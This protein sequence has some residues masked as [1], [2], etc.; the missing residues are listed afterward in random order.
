MITLKSDVDP[1]A[2]LIATEKTVDRFERFKCMPV[3]TKDGKLS[4]E[5]NNA[6]ICVTLDDGKPKKLGSDETNGYLFRIYYE[7]KRI[8]LQCIHALADGRGVVFF[9]SCLIKN[10]YRELSIEVDPDNQLN[11][12]GFFKEYA[13]AEGLFASCQKDMAAQN[14][15]AEDILAAAKEHKA[16]I[17][18]E[19]GKIHFGEMEYYKTPLVGVD[20]LIYDAAKCKEVVSGFGTTVAIFLNMLINK[21]I[22]EEYE[23]EGDYIQSLLPV[24]MRSKFGVTTCDNFCSEM[25]L[26]FYKDWVKDSDEEMIERISADYHEA[27]S[28]ELLISDV[29]EMEKTCEAMQSMIPLTFPDMESLIEKARGK[30]GG[31]T[32]QSNM[33]L[34]RLPGHMGEYVE[35]IDFLPSVVAPDNEFVTSTYGSK[36]RILH[37]S[38]YRDD[39]V[40]KKVYEYMTEYG[41]PAELIPC[42]SVENDHINVSLFKKEA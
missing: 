42:Y 21:A 32:F 39:R 9:L 34:V 12:D 6:K 24:D 17:T 14:I 36:G 25:G 11:E 35:D 16:A 1:D 13:K 7:G 40:L 20:A 2:L 33:G 29:F 41:I 23:I 3:I 22:V 19:K 31:G 4:F 30:D 37:V 10:Y 26:T 27:M 18:G 15:S 5:V 8:Y 38:N 28:D